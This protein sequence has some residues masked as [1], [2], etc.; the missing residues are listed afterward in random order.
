MTGEESRAYAAAHGIEWHYITAEDRVTLDKVPRGLKI[1][2]DLVSGLVDYHQTYAA[3]TGA[4]PTS[5]P[6]VASQWQS[7]VRS[8]EP[9]V[10]EAMQNHPPL[11]LMQLMAK[12]IPPRREAVPALIGEGVTL[13]VGKA[14]L[15]KSWLL[16]GLAL[17]LAWG[18]AA[19]GKIAVQRCEVLL[20]ALEDGEAR[21]QR[22]F[23]SLLRDQT[24]P[25]GVHIFTEW[26]RLDAGG[27]AQLDVYLTE[28][29]DI[30]VVFIDT[31]AKVRPAR[32]R[33]GD[34]YAEDYAVGEMLKAIAERHSVAF[35]VVHHSRKASGEDFVDEVS[36]TTGLTG[37]VDAI[38]VLRRDRGKADA[39][40]CVS[41]RDVEEAEYA[42]TWD[43]PLTQ[44]T[45]AG[46]A[47]DFRRSQTRTD[48]FAVL[49]AAGTP[50]TP[51]QVAERT[52]QPVN[53]VKQRM[54][55]MAKDGELAN[56]V[57]KYVRCH[58]RITAITEESGTQA[59]QGKTP[60][61]VAENEHN[62][63]TGSITGLHDDLP[64][65]NGETGR[66]GY[67]VMP[68]MAVRT[69]SAPS[70]NAPLGEVGA[71]VLFGEAEAAQ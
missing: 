47:E 32:K 22:R 21:L 58:N 9:D 36:G 54:W 30:R 33:G 14:K 41:G 53:T 10:R 39:V 2:S 17:A 68:V 31:L 60:V 28:H 65:Q 57:G 12:D 27:S 1:P 29:P 4:R 70:S 55:Q 67:A 69:N 38:L 26:P 13:F 16:Y 46:N 35:V 19:L 11:T 8:D 3:I 15:G 44:W 51:S 37:G 52:G 5:M 61:M 48:I 24:P 34:L 6:P 56:T 63:I 23:A 66:S 20:L 42:L 62:R 59:T 49:D 43:A 64:L 40:L 50:L 18:G 45:I 71:A 7:I 25:P